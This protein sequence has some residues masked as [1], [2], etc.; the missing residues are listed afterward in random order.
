V[1]FVFFVARIFVVFVAIL[2]TFGFFV[3]IIV[4]FVASVRELEVGP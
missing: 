4:S 3:A 2:V 1:T